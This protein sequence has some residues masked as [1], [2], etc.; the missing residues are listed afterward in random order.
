MDVDLERGETNVRV[1][2]DVSEQEAGDV[3]PDAETDMNDRSLELMTNFDFR[4]GFLM[5]GLI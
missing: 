1:E 2:H 5:D 4:V 3:A